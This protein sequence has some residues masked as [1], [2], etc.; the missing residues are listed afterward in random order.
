MK[1]QTVLATL[2][3]FVRKLLSFLGLHPAARESETVMNDNL[4]QAYIED[5][6]AVP[7]GTKMH[8]GYW[9][10]ASK[11]L[12]TALGKRVYLHQKQKGP[13]WHG[14]QIVGIRTEPY[15]GKER[16]VFIYR[17]ERDCIGVCAPEPNWAPNR[18][19]LIT[20]TA[21]H[22]IHREP[23]GLGTWGPEA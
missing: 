19:Q 7:E 17:S 6:S 16:T 5:P 1:P 23:D 12:D 18:E 8:T 15:Q 14:G 11:D 3:A 4:K 9:R 22:L 13:A 20:D 21:I 2:M 10:I